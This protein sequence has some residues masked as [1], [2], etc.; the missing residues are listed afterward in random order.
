MHKSI[1]L[2]VASLL[3][4]VKRLL[5]LF[6]SLRIVIIARRGLHIYNFIVVKF[7]IEVHAYEIETFYLSVV[8]CRYCKNKMNTRKSGNWQICIK[9]IQAIYLSKLSSYEV[10]FVLVNT[11]VS[12]ALNV[13][14]PF[15]V[16]Y[17]CIL[18]ALNCMPCICSF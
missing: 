1:I 16:D 14:N 8:A 15:A 6:N 13:E 4:P 18:W 5:K 9:I 12:V 7:A 3:K 17:I 2:F 10:G 11:A